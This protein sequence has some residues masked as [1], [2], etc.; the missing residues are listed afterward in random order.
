MEVGMNTTAIIST[1]TSILQQ[2][3]PIF[4]APGAKIFARLLNGWILCTVRRTVTRMLPFADPAGEHAHD[5]FHRFFPDARWSMARLWNILTRMLINTFCRTDV[6][7]LALDDTLFHH[8][9]KKVN[10]A[11]YWR[12]AVRSTKTKTVYAWGLNLVVLTLQIQP[13]WGGEPLGLPI[14]MR[15]HRKNQASL[16]ELAEQ[17]INEVVPWFPQRRFRVVGDGFYA[18]LAGKELVTTIISRI[19][20]NAEIYDLPVRPRRKGRGRPRKKGKRLAYPEKMARYVHDWQK[21]KVRE[22]GKIKTRLV[23][24][25]KVLWY[26]VSHQPI[27]LVISRDPAGKEKDDFFFTTGVTM[28]PAKVIGIYSD[29]WCIEDTFKN[30]KQFLG[31]Q[32]PQTWK[33]QGPKRA[34]ALSLWLYSVVWLW[35]LRQKSSKRYFIVQPWNPLKSMPSFADALSCLRRELWRERIKCMFGVSAVHDKKI[36]FLLEALA[37]A[38]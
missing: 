30:T 33:R 11:G 15:L 27:L 31:G 37:P 21:V 8:S 16:I 12:D 7:T 38:A 4:T 17:M 20:R 1:W 19:Q 14:N 26:R 24:A 35:Y 34:A 18:P 5:A 9:G 32:E 36:E 28:D 3:I 29:R 13:P 2:F 22:R 6:I 10:G 23:Y 25:R